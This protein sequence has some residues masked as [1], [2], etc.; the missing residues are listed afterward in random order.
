MLSYFGD[1][2]PFPV[3]LT[4]PWEQFEYLTTLQALED[5]PAFAQA[6]RHPHTGVDLSPRKA[7]W[8]FIGCSYAGAR[9]VFSR[10]KHPETFHAA[11]ASSATVEAEN[12][13]NMYFSK[14]TAEWLA[15][16]MKIVLKACVKLYSM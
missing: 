14:C 3:N 8:V 13:G 10:A 11:Y 2:V 15:T 12:N 1:S 16:A 7:P 5:I 6:F 9:A 4:T